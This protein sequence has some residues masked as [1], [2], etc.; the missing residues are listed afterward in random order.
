MFEMN[1]AVYELSEFTVVCYGRGALKHIR[2]SLSNFCFY[3]E[4]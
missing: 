3:G 2:I 1:M 4:V